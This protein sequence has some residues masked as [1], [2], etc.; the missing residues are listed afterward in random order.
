[1]ERMYVVF[2]GILIGA[3]MGMLTGHIA[4]WICAGLAMGVVLAIAARRR[5]KDPVQPQQLKADS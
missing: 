4:G 2:A 3:A 1:M 5:S